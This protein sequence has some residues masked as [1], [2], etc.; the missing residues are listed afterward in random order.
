[1]ALLSDSSQSRAHLGFAENTFPR[2]KLGEHC[3]GKI[4]EKDDV[5]R[6]VEYSAWHRLSTAERGQ[7]TWCHSLRNNLPPGRETAGK[8]AKAGPIRQ[9]CRR[10][11]LVPR[12]RAVFVQF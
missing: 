6:E 11:L 12:E 3:L 9:S 10:N 1:M 2:L 4:T 5:C 7:G 8:Q